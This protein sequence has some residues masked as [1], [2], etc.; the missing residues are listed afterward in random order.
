M[1]M[2]HLLLKINYVVSMVVGRA[3]LSSLLRDDPADR[4][5]DVPAEEEAR[6]SREV[7]I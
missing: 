5:K 7:R 1:L 6:E 2:A 3:S 4:V